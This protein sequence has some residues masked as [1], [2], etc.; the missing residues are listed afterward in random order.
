MMD[1]FPVDAAVLQLT[2]GGGEERLSLLNHRNPRSTPM[3]RA[4][5]DNIG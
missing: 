5:T 4:S 1:P 2:P 3:V